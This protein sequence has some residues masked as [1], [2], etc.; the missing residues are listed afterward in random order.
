MRADVRNRSSAIPVEVFRCEI[1]Q[2]HS[3][4]PHDAKDIA[5]T[6]FM[7]TADRRLGEESGSGIGRPNRGDTAADRQQKAKEHQDHRRVRDC[8]KLCVSGVI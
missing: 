1:E 2:C 3:T 7:K 6:T 4:N 5:Q 8:P